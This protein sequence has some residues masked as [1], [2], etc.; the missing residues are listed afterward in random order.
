MAL[1]VKLQFLGS[2]SGSAAVMAGVNIR[3][4]SM[5]EQLWLD[6]KEE[7]LWRF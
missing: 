6:A 7:W 3:C 5:A 2:C 4:N 1:L